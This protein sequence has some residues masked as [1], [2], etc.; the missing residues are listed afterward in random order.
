ML[1]VLFGPDEFRASEALRSLRDTLDTDGSLA[2]NTTTIPGRNLSPSELIQHASALPFLAPVRLVIVENLLTSLGSR[3]G[4]VDTWQPFLDFLPSMPETNHVVLIESPK[5][6]DRDS[7]VA[8]SPLLG[9]LKQRPNVTVTEFQELKTWA[10]GGP[11][12]V[13]QWLQDRAV[14]RGISIQPQA[15][16]AMAEMVGAN[17]RALAAELEKLATYADGRTITADDVRLLTPVVREERI[18]DLV[19]AIVEGHAANALKLLRRMLDD[20]SETPAHVQLLVARQL[21]LLVRATEILEGRGSQED[22]ASITKT[23]GFPLTKLMR[24]ARS[25]HRGAAE[26]ALR[27]VEA[28]D[29]SIKTGKYTDELAIELLVVQLA[30]LA[31]RHTRARR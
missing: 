28:T 21:R 24:Q 20:G 29:H 7:S 4:L 1:H 12:E 2:S 27:A 18:F 16:E 10:R 17:L 31:P 3:R 19:D 13:A 15:I 8:R 26:A 11:S 23:R 25:T 6:D 22:V 30:S 14:R 5:R 9:A